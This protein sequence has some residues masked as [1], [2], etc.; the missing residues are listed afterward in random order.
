MEIPRARK[1]IAQGLVCKLH[2]YLHGYEEPM[3]FENVL[4]FLRE[5]AVLVQGGHGRGMCYHGMACEG[6]ELL[7]D[8]VGGAGSL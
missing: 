8:L 2:C 5:K 6:R 3:Q 1:K 7:S 4:S